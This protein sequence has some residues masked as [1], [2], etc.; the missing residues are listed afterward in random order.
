ML[1]LFYN[2]LR[3]ESI[4]SDLVLKQYNLDDIV[5]QA[6]RKY[7]KMFIR[8]RIKLNFNDLNCT[9]LTDEKWILFVIEQIL[10]N[11]LKY[12]KEGSISIY[13]DKKLKKH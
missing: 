6:V 4:S 12:T 5:K 13:M 7:A 11:A 1:N 3:L 9:V 10:S 2:I 8:K